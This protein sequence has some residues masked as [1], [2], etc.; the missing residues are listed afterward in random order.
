[1]NNAV[2][3]SSLIERIRAEL[4]LKLLLTVALNVVVWTPYLTLQH[5][6]FFPATP[7]PMSFI[8]TAIGFSPGAVWAYLSVYLL[9]PIGPFLMVDRERIFC[10]ARGIVVMAI[11]AVIVFV[12]FPTICARPQGGPTNALYRAFVAFD[13]PYHA[14]PSLHAAFAIYSAL[15]AIEVGR[16]LRWLTGF[17]I[18]F[19]IWAAVILYATLATRQHVFA[20]IVAGGLLGLGAYQFC[21][22][23]SQSNNLLQRTEV[24][25]EN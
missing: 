6:H 1:M 25:Y 3:T 10:Y 15:C 7:M 13:N 12:F 17:E 22:R 20:D 9:L 16:A 5:L 2:H 14:F 24:S 8:D 18:V 11:V 4:R 23:R 19:W 21:L